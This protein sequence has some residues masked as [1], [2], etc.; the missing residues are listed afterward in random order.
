MFV[1]NDTAKLA[2]EWG[3]TLFQQDEKDRP[4]F[5]GEIVRSYIDGGTIKYFSNRERAFLSW[6]NSF[7]LIGLLLVLLGIDN[8]C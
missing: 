7:L 6:R 2:L 5:K 8:R 3:T 1:F 4:S